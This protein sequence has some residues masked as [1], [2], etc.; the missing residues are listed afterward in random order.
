MRSV[1]WF[2][3]SLLLIGC[4]YVAFAAAQAGGA[5]ETAAAQALAAGRFK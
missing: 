4:G 3:V 2:V 1:R 5:D